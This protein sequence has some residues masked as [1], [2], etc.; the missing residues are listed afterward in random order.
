MNINIIKI[1]LFIVELPMITPFVVSFGTIDKRRLVV[2]KL[3]DREG[4]CGWGEAATL[5]QPIFKPDYVDSVFSVIE[6]IMG[7][8]LLRSGTFSSPEDFD[9]SLSFVKGHYFAKAA[10]SMAAYDIAAQKEGKILSDY[11]GGTKT[12]IPLSRTLSIMHDSKEMLDVASHM[13][14]DGFRDLK[15]KIKPGADLI[16]AKTLREQYPNLPLMV[17]ANAAYRFSEETIALFLELDKLDLF[18]I[19]QPLDWNDLYDHSQLQKLL[20]TAIALD[21]SVDCFHDFEQALALKSC[22]LLNIKVPRVGGLSAA[23]SLYEMGIKNSIGMW[24]GGMIE[25]PIGLASV[26]AFSTLEGLNLPADYIDS[27]YLIKDFQNYFDSVP[28]TLSE[29]YLTPHFSGSGLGFKINFDRLCAA[30]IAH[31][32]LDYK[33]AA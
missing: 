32:K 27:H 23:R 21:E 33:A 30:P 16:F 18:C 24:V 1:D 28:Y 31:I 17:D 14:S 11:I 6:K 19:E 20:K 22:R 7:P 15:L 8:F 25:G 5:D 13:V 4:V 2:V 10:L 29:G 9:H 12:R 26:M 3:T